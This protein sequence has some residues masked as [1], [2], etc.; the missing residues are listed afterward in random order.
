[1]DWADLTSKIHW[2][3]LTSCLG[4]ESPALNKCSFG[5]LVWIPSVGDHEGPKAWPWIATG[6][7]K[8]S[9]VTFGAVFVE[10]GDGFFCKVYSFWTCLLKFYHTLQKFVLLHLRNSAILNLSESTSI[11]IRTLTNCLQIL[12]SRDQARNL[13][14]NPIPTSLTIQCLGYPSDWSIS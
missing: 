5:G 2:W 14:C 8:S 11:V 6:M 13:N 10:P 9:P 1:M 12:S 3:K 4:I 7:T